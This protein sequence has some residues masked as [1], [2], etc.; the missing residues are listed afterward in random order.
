MNDEIRVGDMVTI[1]EDPN[2]KGY[3]KLPM[4]GETGEVAAMFPQSIHDGFNFTG[5]E[6]CIKFGQEGFNLAYGAYDKDEVTKC[7]KQ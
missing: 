2:P 6:L 3:G 1:T 7:P 4:A 5:W